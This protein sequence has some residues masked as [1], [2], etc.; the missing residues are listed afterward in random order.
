MLLH[1]MSAA[2][3]AQAAPSSEI[4]SYWSVGISE[5]A[6]LASRFDFPGGKPPPTVV[7][8]MTASDTGRLDLRIALE[9]GHS[10]ADPFAMAMV[11]KI[12]L[13]DQEG[14]AIGEYWT[15]SSDA[16]KGDPTRFAIVL[17]PRLSDSKARRA[18]EL[19]GETR[20]KAMTDTLHADLRRDLARAA[21][22]ELVAVTPTA[23]DLKFDMG[24]KAM[25]RAMD[26]L[27]TCR[28]RLATGA[29]YADNFRIE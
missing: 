29:K 13:R 5:G 6:C 14:A 12:R 25:G 20:V 2:A 8:G 21:R 17:S 16:F 19:G 3:L 15:R 26:S 7:W 4:V 18:R 9:P 10:L 27:S 24:M 1:L 28:T 23:N 11:N 22:L